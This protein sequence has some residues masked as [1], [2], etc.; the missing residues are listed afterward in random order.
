MI[1]RARQKI[2]AGN[3]TFELADIT[4]PWPCAANSTDLVVCNLVLE[5]IE[6]IGFVFSEAARV[7]RNEGRYFVSELHPFRQ[8][9]GVQA[10]FIRG[11]ERTEIPAFDHHLTDFLGSAAAHNLSLLQLK[12]SWHPEDRNKPPRLVSFIFAKQAQ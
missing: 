10:R 2:S 12:E 6:N 4:Q 9:Q 11:E 8:Y 1:A 3:V 7:L 5:H